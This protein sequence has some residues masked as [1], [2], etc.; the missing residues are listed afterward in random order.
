MKEKY[1]NTKYGKVFLRIDNEKCK[2]KTLILL[3]G[4]GMDL[5]TF[6]N[7][8]NKL[9]NI[10]IIRFDFLG[11]GKSSD[12]VKPIGVKEYAECLHEII[13]RYTYESE[14][15]LL[16]HSFGGR[17]GIYYTSRYKNTN[18]KKMFLV[19]AKAL[20]NRSLS[21]RFKV[22]I[23]KTKKRFLRIFRKRK[24]VNYIKDKGSRDY[25]MLNDMMKKSFVKIVNYDLRKHL[26]KVKVETI[27]IGS[28]HDSEVSFEETLTIHN[29][30]KNSKLYPCFNSGHFTYID[31]ESKVISIIKKTM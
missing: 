3:H 11:F 25:K 28:I 7:I 2:E 9:N 10:R 20:K 4:F 29:K 14:L 18:V 6:N 23:Y 12:P 27:V 24:Y 16:G 30:I 1:I 19:N 13:N 22:L 15:Y 8:V 31:E 5:A 21:F 26:R 17:V